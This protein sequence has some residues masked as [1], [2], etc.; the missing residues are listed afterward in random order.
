MVTNDSLPAG[1][2]LFI[3]LNMHLLICFV[4][5]YVYAGISDFVPLIGI[6]SIFLRSLG[7]PAG[8]GDCIDADSV[9]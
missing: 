5:S 7:A 9:S 4:N 1:V 3:I 8:T 6:P 2:L